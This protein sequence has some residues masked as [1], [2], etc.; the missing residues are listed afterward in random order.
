MTCETPESEAPSSDDLNDEED[1]SIPDTNDEDLN[2]EYESDCVLNH[3]LASQIIKTLYG[4][5][6]RTIT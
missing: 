5:F 3:R 6:T 2:I 1:S 4:W